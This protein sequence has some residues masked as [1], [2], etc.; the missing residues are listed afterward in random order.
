[1][2]LLGLPL[3]VDRHCQI[4]VEQ[5]DGLHTDQLRKRV[6]GLDLSVI[7][8]LYFRLL[9]PTSVKNG[10]EPLIGRMSNF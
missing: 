2:S 3:E 10:I 7:R 8:A 4:A 6:L 9:S 5:L 1:V